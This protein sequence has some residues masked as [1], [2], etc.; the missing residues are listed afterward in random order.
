MLFADRSLAR[1][2]EAIGCLRS[3]PTVGGAITEPKENNTV[4]PFSTPRS[5]T[6]AVVAGLLAA[7]VAAVSLGTQAV[8]QTAELDKNVTVNGQGSSFMSNF[9]DLCRADVKTSLGINVAYQP[10]GS[11]AGRSGFIAG[12]IDWAGSDVPFTGT[13]LTSLKGKA[14]RYVPITTGGVAVAYRLSGV[15]EIKLTGPTLAKVFLGQA[16][17]WN[18]EAIAKDNPGVALPD[19]PVK[20]VVRS[21][22]SGTSNVFSDYLSVASKGLWKAGAVSNFPVPSGNGIAQR[23]SDGVTNYLQS[24]QGE[25]AITYT[26]VSFASERKLS[27][28]KVV[29]ASGTAVAPDPANV[30]IAMQ[31]AAIN[32]DGTLLLNFNASDPKAYPISTAAYAIIAE[33]MDKNKG[34]VL[35]T[36]LTYTLTTCQAKGERLG[37]APLPKNLVDL[38]L[39]AVA[40]INPGSAP[41]P[42]IAGAP[43]ATTPASSAPAATAAPTTAAPT[44]AKAPATT[45]PKAKTTKKKSTTATTKKK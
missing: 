6:A 7:N 1:H 30:Q 25:G 5:K 2:L 42:T 26:E 17:R 39:A 38:G 45:K 27:V 21:D 11:G 20:V 31:A 43:A 24:G 12:N 15:A 37:Y 3:V 28:A 44:T 10:S 19:T 14:F 36:Y 16:Q 32:D 13:E 41:V 8:A 9:V 23:G 22:S 35:R 40:K 18:D 29:N 33:S 4:S 34:D